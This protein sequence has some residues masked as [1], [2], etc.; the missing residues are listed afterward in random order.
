[1]IQHIKNSIWFNGRIINLLIYMRLIIKNSLFNIF[2]LFFTIIENKIKEL[3]DKK[4]SIHE[5]KR[6]FEKT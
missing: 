5:F 3:F 1:M 4:G 2:Q 6:F